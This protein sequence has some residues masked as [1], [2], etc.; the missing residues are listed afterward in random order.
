MIQVISIIKRHHLKTKNK[1][2]KTTLFKEVIA[3]MQA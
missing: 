2:S 3:Y 1:A